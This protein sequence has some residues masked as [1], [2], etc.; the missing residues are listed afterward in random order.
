MHSFKTWLKQIP[1]RNVPDLANPAP[2]SS[3]SSD[4]LAE[5]G[6]DGLLVYESDHNDDLIQFYH[7]FT[8]IFFSILTFF[9]FETFILLYLLVVVALMTFSSRRTC[10][11]QVLSGCVLS[12]RPISLAGCASPVIDITYQEYQGQQYQQLDQYCYKNTSPQCQSEKIH[13]PRL[14]V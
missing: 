11:W 5:D 3:S 14:F 9:M 12:H 8:H 6:D 2:E 1:S 10:F 7:S 13:S 4:P